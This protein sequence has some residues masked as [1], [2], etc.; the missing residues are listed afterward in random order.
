MSGKIGRPPKDSENID[1]KQK[2]I[3]TTIA[4]IKD[5]GADQVTVRNVC[6]AAGLSIGT[7]YHHFRD[8]DDL[9]MCFVADSIFKKKKLRTSTDDPAGRIVELYSTLIDQYQSLGSDFM[10][11][12]YT[13][14]NTALSAYLGQTDGQFMSGSIMARSEQEIVIAVAENKLSGISNPHQAASDICTIIKGCV[15]EWCLSGCSID[16]PETMDRIIR[17]YLSQ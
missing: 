11:S 13:T 14:G 1:C 8:K 12:F 7:F 16:L 5:Q 2:I 15:F 10:K 3:D 6:K 9:M 4:L 17:N